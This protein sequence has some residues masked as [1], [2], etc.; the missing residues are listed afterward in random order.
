MKE[1]T[2]KEMA[3]RIKLEYAN[4][5]SPFRHQLRLLAWGAPMLALVYLVV[6]NSVRTTEWAYSPGPVSAEHA[7]FGNEC[8][9]CH[10]TWSEVKDVSCV[11]C[12]EAPMHHATLKIVEPRCATCH[13]EHRG[14]DALVDVPDKQCLQCHTDLQKVYAGTKIE[15]QILH[16]TKGHPEFVK[17]REKRKDESQLIFNHKIHLLPE[18]GA[19]AKIAEDLGLAGRESDSLTCTDCHRVDKG[20]RY[21]VP[22]NYAKHCGY[23]HT[24]Q[25]LFDEKDFPKEEAPHDTPQRIHESLMNRVFEFAAS[26][27]P[28]PTPKAEEEEEEDDW[29]ER[30]GGD[31][32]EETAEVIEPTLPWVTE[33]VE[34]IENLLYKRNPQACAKCHHFEDVKDV[35]KDAAYHKKLVTVPTRVPARWF[36]NSN[37]DH[38]A[39][40]TLACAVCHA[41]A[42]TSTTVEDVLVP[43]I[44]SCTDCHKEEGGARSQCVRC[45]FY[46]KKHEE[47]GLEG[48]LEM[49]GL[50][51]K[52]PNH[53]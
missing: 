28:T 4:K 12:H 16:F 34:K 33:R 5:K 23:C 43:G 7:I 30:G 32:K 20:G 1:V 29:G 36:E 39:H 27:R 15:R 21:M 11:G 18:K 45:H 37:F 13:Q 50:M 9:S 38:R 49:R 40:R 25:L 44:K 53:P 22:I 46:H 8:T 52:E 14:M 17:I 6:L 26:P 51:G 10:T 24:H 41:E 35:P 47:K 48:K 19:K 3:S 42:K 31:E 2:T